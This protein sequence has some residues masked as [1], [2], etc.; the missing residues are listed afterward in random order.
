MLFNF[1]QPNSPY[2]DFLVLFGETNSYNLLNSSNFST[3]E[4]YLNSFQN[5][6][7]TFFKATLM[8]ED[9]E[10]I[11]HNK[12]YTSDTGIDMR[13]ANHE[14]KRALSDRDKC[15]NQLM[16]Q[17]APGLRDV[18]SNCVHLSLQVNNHHIVIFAD[19]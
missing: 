8:F 4:L 3:I 5:E 14:I 9:K 10:I 13:N 15:I 6:K 16:S 18:I 1:V 7:L 17:N 19:I 11:L 2:S 12:T